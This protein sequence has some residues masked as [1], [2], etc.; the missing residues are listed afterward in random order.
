MNIISSKSLPCLRVE[1]CGEGGGL[2]GVGEARRDLMGVG[3]EEGDYMTTHT[4]NAHLRGDS[5]GGFHETFEPVFSS[6]RQ[7]LNSRPELFTLK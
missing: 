2:G 6:L 3:R 7:T 5:A 4:P 1:Q